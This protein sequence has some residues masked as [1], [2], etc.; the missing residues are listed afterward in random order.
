M[1][2]TVDT[3]TENVRTGT[4]SPQTFSHAGAASGVK[5]VVLAI[6]H[7]TSSTDHVSA[8]SYG[9]VALTRKQRNTDT[10]TEPG[11]AELWFLG[12]GVPQGTQTVSYTPG[13]TT[14][15]IHAVCITLLAADD[16]EVIDNDGVD[17]NVANPSVTLQYGGRSCMSF[18]ALYGGGAD[19]SAFTP[20]G[21]CTTVFDEDLGA[22]YSEV[23]RQTTAGTSD[24]AIGGT[25]STDDVAFA[26]IAV[27]EVIAGATGTMASTL[28]AVTVAATGAMVF[29][30]TSAISLPGV[31][32]SSSG[33]HTQ[34]AD[35]YIVRE[36]NSGDKIL[37]EDNSKLIT[38]GAIAALD[39]TSAITLS[40]VTVSATGA[41]VFS[42]TATIT[43]PSVTTA[44]TGAETFA[45]TSAIALP[46]ITVAGA[47]LHPY[48]GSAS[49][50]LGS[51]T[52]A[53]TGAQV[54]AGTSAVTLTPVTV[55][56]SGLETFS[57]TAAI[58]LPTVTVAATGA[59]VFTATSA[60][61]LPAVTV[62]AAGTHAE[63]G[64]FTGVADITLASIAV[65]ASG[66]YEAPAQTDQGTIAGGDLFWASGLRRRAP[67]DEAANDETEDEAAIFLLM[68]A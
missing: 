49:I 30:A 35:G 66:A 52:T 9:G 33:T 55:S 28:A 24:F 63:A 21:N 15:D 60:V 47:G 45:G 25:S 67:D 56:S 22:F 34:A 32:S 7:G 46:A 59:E 6:V 3:S 41:L 23:I 68:A 65:S 39:A 4:T 61:V 31:T 5:G 38:E 1:T 48:I 11:A 58:S 14:D 26:A 13:A 40:A 54:F 64:V 8:A 37:A 20:N 50:T 62:D 18:A 16:T 43:L 17:N 36:D 29:S 44:A 53:A 27:S 57:A 12:A 51:V 2:I 42:G 19:G 10:A